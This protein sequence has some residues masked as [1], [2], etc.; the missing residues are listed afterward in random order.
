[1]GFTTDG[2]DARSR[3]IRVVIGAVLVAIAYFGADVLF[4]LFLPYNFAKLVA[5]FVLAVAGVFLTPLVFNKI[6]KRH[7]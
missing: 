4:K 2:L 7:G 3:V 5:R 1:M 6:E